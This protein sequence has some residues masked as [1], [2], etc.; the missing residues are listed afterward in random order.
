MTD[1]P[2]DETPRSEATA[3][4]A[5]ARVPWYRRREMRRR[6][7]L[8]VLVVGVASLLAYWSRNKPVKVT[9]IY[10]LGRLAPR[11][12]R[13][14]LSYHRSGHEEQPVDISFPDQAPKSYRHTL[15]LIPGDYTITARIFLRATDERGAE[16][17]HHLRRVT[18]E[19]GQD[20]RLRLRLSR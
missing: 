12:T 10:D 13:I 17:R 19:S 4:T 18:I 5:P 15:Q 7:A 3:P 11:V 8:L 6:V 2:S 9:V 20:Q 14:T 16:V 1:T